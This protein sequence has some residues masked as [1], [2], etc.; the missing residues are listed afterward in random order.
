MFCLLGLDDLKPFHL[1][2]SLFVVSTSNNQC[3]SPRLLITTLQSSTEALTLVHLFFCCL[4]SLGFLFLIFFLFNFILLAVSQELKTTIVIINSF[5]HFLF[6]DGCCLSLSLSHV[7]IE[8]IT[9]D[10]NSSFFFHLF[11]SKCL[12]ENSSTYDD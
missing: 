9:L 2:F 8:L 11:S 3:L 4:S 7:S 10:D 12:Q 5:A 6:T 1:F